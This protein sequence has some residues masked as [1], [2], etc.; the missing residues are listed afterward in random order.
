MDYSRFAHVG[1]DTSDNEA[2]RLS[3]HE[4]EHFFREAFLSAC[5]AA[6]PTGVGDLVVLCDLSGNAALNG[7]H[8]RVEAFD[9]SSGRSQ[10]CASRGKRA[11]DCRQAFQL[12]AT[13]LPS[14]WNAF[15][16]GLG[17]PTRWRQRMGGG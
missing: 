10:R 4:L 11:A 6:H 7:C 9:F 15:G 16:E 14:T 5:E 2:S 3:L 8:G 17:R 12:H 1:A 13:A